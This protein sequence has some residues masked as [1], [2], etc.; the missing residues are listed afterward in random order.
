[1]REQM[2][3]EHQRNQWRYELSMQNLLARLTMQLN[4]KFS[5]MTFRDAVSQQDAKKSH[6]FTASPRDA[7]DM[8]DTS[9]SGTTVSRSQ[10]TQTFNNRARMPRNPANKAR[11][12]A[13]PPTNDKGK[14]ST[15]ASSKKT[16]V[17]RI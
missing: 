11:P 12:L 15:N 2:L 3:L 8:D 14:Q 16:P 7:S 10:S 5:D 17:W 9:S 6:S 13:Q 1:M 4:A